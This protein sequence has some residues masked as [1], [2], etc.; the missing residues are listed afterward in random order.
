MGVKAVAAVLLAITAVAGAAWGL[1]LF[2]VP[3]LMAT[4][5]SAAGG[6]LVT[7][8]TIMVSESIQE[9]REFVQKNLDRIKET[10]TSTVYVTETQVQ[11]AKILEERG[12]ANPE[13]KMIAHPGLY[14][15][16]SLGTY[17]MVEIP[18]EPKIPFDCLRPVIEQ[19][20]TDR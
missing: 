4:W 15:R 14:Q 8:F 10:H 17:R 20:D 6:G 1:I 5:I 18:D 19:Q 3:P 16:D 7:A 2:G 9:S 13:V 12:Q 11:A